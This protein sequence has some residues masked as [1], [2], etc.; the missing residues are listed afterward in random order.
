MANSETRRRIAVFGAGYLGAT[1]AACM[2]ELGHDVIG[3]DVD[4]ER[5]RTLQE[6]KV[7]F[8][9]PG[10]DELIA[11]HTATGRLRF[12]ASYDEAAAQAD[13]HFIGVGTP[14][15]A[16]SGAADL[17]QIDAVIDA[18]APL[19]TDGSVVLGKS[20]VPVGTAD[21]IA[22]RVREL[23]PGRDVAVGWNPEFLREGTAVEDTLRPDRVVVGASA[24]DADRV[25][26]A[27]RD[28]YA[29]PLAE[30]TPF[31]ETDLA[32]AE[33]VKVSANS[34]LATKLSFINAVSEVCDLVGAD[35]TM[36]AVA[37]GLDER[38]GKSYL[39]AGVGYGGACLPK[40]V[41]AFHAR[42]AELGARGIPDLLGGVDR[43]NAL[44]RSRVTDLVAQACPE[45]GTVAML[46][47]AFKA[48][49]DDVRDSAAL[50]VASRLIAQGRT[51]RAWDPQANA[52]AARVQPALRL[53]ASAEEAC[54]SADVVVVMTPWDEI[55][56]LD[57]AELASIVGTRSVIDARNCLDPAAWTAAGWT[58]RGIGRS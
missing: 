40:D 49:S 30:G 21:Y 32:T 10:L 28:V 7:P 26:A 9:E 11:R 17:S 44:Q 52:N 47:L 38:I 27:A 48:D 25:S 36:L 20:T 41:R 34:F 31:L 23:A 18:L 35:V 19:L 14:Q 46:G 15:R 54:R 33:L 53:A 51:V 6:G 16:D 1:H 50:D 4:P 57:P 8:Y 45:G 29:R 13:V 56:E 2:A 55:R 5:I 39:Q 22:G 43:I 58:Y 37:L 12:T 24:D 3:V 42:A